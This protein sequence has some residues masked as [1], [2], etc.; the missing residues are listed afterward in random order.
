[1]KKIQKS[2]HKAIFYGSIYAQGFRLIIE[3]EKDDFFS[4]KMKEVLS[5]TLFEATLKIISFSP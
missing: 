1:M 2:V 3:A 4:P 5:L